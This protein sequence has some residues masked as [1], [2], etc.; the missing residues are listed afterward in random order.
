MALINNFWVLSTTGIPLFLL[1]GD[2][3]QNI[4]IGGFFSALQILIDKV[5]ESPFNKIELENRT[6]FYYFM[7]PII[8]VLEAEAKNETETQVL[9]II[10]QKLGKAFLELYPAEKIEELCGDLSSCKEFYAKYEEIVADIEQMM[11]Q[12]HK[13]FLT[14]YFVEAAN[15]ENILGIVIYDLEK[16]EIISR[17]TPP[18]CSVEDFESFGSMLFSFLGRLGKELK[19]GKINEVLLR[20]QEYWVGGFRKGTLAVFM[21]F[22]L[23]YFGKVLPDFVNAPLEKLE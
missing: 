12:S 19:T 10:T 7:E 5:E 21:L 23:K 3:Q 8:S 6:Y 4:L 14:K 1:K 11:Q 22:D 15:D 16:D 18:D 13:E 9:Q 17:D 2:K 20:G